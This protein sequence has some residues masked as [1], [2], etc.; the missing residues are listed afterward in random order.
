MI[1]GALLMFGWAFML[2]CI[3]AVIFVPERKFVNQEDWI[4]LVVIFIAAVISQS[5]GF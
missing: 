5:L 2:F 1:S 3:W 4:A